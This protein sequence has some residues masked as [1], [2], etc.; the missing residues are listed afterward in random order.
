LIKFFIVINLI[1]NSSKDLDHFD[2]AKS[3]HW[4]PENISPAL[5]ENSNTAE[6]DSFEEEISIGEINEM[7]KKN[8]RN[9]V[10][11]SFDHL[12]YPEANGVYQINAPIFTK[13]LYLPAAEKE[14]NQLNEIS[15]GENISEEVIPDLKLKE[16][17]SKFEYAIEFNTNNK[18]F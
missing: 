1:C 13:N 18:E 2:D 9:N 7:D 17:Q 10:Y 5:L 12:G 4:T 11:L 16:D 6:N 3:N 15:S 14:N 8:F